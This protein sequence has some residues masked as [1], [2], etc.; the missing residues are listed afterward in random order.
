MESCTHATGEEAWQTIEKW[1]RMRSKH[2]TSM[3]K[4]RMGAGTNAHHND[5]LQ[6]VGDEGQK[7]EVEHFER[8]RL[9]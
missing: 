7:P 3:K 8:R 9:D 1:L 4:I 2:M 5:H 6:D